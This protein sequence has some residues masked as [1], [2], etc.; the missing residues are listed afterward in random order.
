M[1][2]ITPKKD[3][4]F[5]Y[6]DAEL[7]SKPL[8]NRQWMYFRNL[9][10]I[11]SSR[12]LLDWISITFVRN[13]HIEY[14]YSSGKLCDFS[15]LDDIFGNDPDMRWARYYLESDPSGML[16]L[17]HSRETDRLRALNA[18]GQTSSQDFRKH[19]ETYFPKKFPEHFVFSQ[20]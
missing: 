20:K 13:P 6:D 5:V 2:I 9:S 8:Y 11:T 3:I 4:I 16:P 7:R 10:A 12:K 1:A 19:M 14:R 15:D 17:R 18:S